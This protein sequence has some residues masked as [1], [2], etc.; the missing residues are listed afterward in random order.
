MATTPTCVYC[1][2]PLAQG[3]PALHAL[4]LPRRKPRNP[5]SPASQRPPRDPPRPPPKNHSGQAS[6]AVVQPPVPILASTSRPATPR[7]AKQR[8]NLL[9]PPGPTVPGGAHAPTHPW[10]G[11]LPSATAKDGA[12]RLDH[13]TAKTTPPPRLVQSKTIRARA[14]SNRDALTVEYDSGLEGSHWTP[15]LDSTGLEWTYLGTEEA[16][17]YALSTGRL[18]PPRGDSNL[19]GF[20]ISRNGQT[21]YRPDYWLPQLGLYLE[22]KPTGRNIKPELWKY[23]AFKRELHAGR[24]PGR[25]AVVVKGKPTARKVAQL[26]DREEAA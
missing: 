16:W 6:T 24:W 10:H 7:A 9:A 2:R 15:A 17:F 3:R 4:V 23:V 19:A 5:S 8:A 12:G 22:I 14:N 11:G 21:T 25:D 18:A 13:Q 20:P 26:I 1:R